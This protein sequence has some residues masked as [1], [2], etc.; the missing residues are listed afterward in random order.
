MTANDRLRRAV[1][2][3]RLL[4]VLVL[5][6]TAVAG[7]PDREP[8][9][10]GLRVVTYNVK[11]GRGMDGTIDLERIAGVLRERRPDVVALQEIDRNA[12]RSGGRDQADELGRALSMHHAFG[13]FMPFQGGD[14]GMAILSR[15]PITKTTS[16]RLPDGNEPRIALVV[17]IR[18]PDDRTILVVNVHFDWIADDAFRFAQ[19]QVVADF[20]RTA[21]RP[22]VLLGDF[23]DTPGSR[24]LALFEAVGSEADKPEAGR[25][26][27]PADE[28]VKE[29]DFVWYGPPRAWEPRRTRVVDERVASDHRPVVADLEL[30]P[31]ATGAPRP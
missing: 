17:E 2:L 22:F 1:H 29:I 16:L 19:A 8:P 24:T 5:A 30:R 13:A 12:T 18:L 20:L 28:P 25:L 7:T 14:Y 4:L 10:T 11:H 31:D 21:E 6:C 3:S 26:T 27:F 15:H 23:N 9:G